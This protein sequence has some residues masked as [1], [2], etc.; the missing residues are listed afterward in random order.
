L[1]VRCGVVRLLIM[2]EG[3]IA[4][5]GAITGTAALAWSTVVWV[6][7]RRTKAIVSGGYSRSGI[8]IRVVNRC[9][10]QIQVV[11]VGATD[12]EAD[13]AYCADVSSTMKFDD[14]G[15]ND[16]LQ[17]VEGSGDIGPWREERL[18]LKS[19]QLTARSAAIWDEW[20]QG[21]EKV[22]S[23][24]TEGPLQ[25]P[26]RE[27]RAGSRPRGNV[28]GTVWI[29]VAAGKRFCGMLYTSGV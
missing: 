5:I 14:I 19:P 17:V 26:A 6:I 13:A 23:A 3:P 1:T 9:S 27:I 12:K 10:H 15:L 2:S 4:Y 22:R 16:P 24:G 21:L 28:R 7:E 29:Q 18:L 20:L 11:S 8:E 25:G